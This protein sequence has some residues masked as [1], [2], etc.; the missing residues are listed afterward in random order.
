MT[1]HDLNPDQLLQLKQSM[2]CERM[3]AKDE[4]PAYGDLD[5]A[6]EIISDMEVMSQYA[7]VNFVPDDFFC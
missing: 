6:D 4:S 3:D 7:G 2:L 5:E 1:V